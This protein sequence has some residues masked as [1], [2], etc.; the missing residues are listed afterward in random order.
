MKKET[1]INQIAHSLNVVDARPEDSS[2][3]TRVEIVV[4]AR[5]PRFPVPTSG[6]AYV[7]RRECERYERPPEDEAIRRFRPLVN[8]RRRLS[9]NA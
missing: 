1:T 3:L 7:R 9:V 4:A 2:R 6:F 8:S 5:R